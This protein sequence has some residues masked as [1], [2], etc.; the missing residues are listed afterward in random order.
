MHS[1]DWNSLFVAQWAEVRLSVDMGVRSVGPT[2]CCG[3]T[4]VGRSGTTDNT[5]TNFF[6]YF[7]HALADRKS[8]LK[9]LDGTSECCVRGDTRIGRRQLLIYLNHHQSNNCIVQEK[10]RRIMTQTTPSVRAT[11]FSCPHCGA[12]AKQ[13]WH[14]VWS[15]RR[16][17]KHPQPNIITPEQESTL[18]FSAGGPEVEAELRAWAKK[19]ASGIPHLEQSG[20]GQWIRNQVQNVNLSSCYNCKKLSVWIF[21]RLVYPTTNTSLAANPDMPEDVRRDYDEA[22]TIVKESPRGAAAL[23]RLAIQKLCRQLGQPGKN[24]NADIAALVK[25]GL[26]TRV[27]Q[28][29]DVVRVVGNNAVHPGQID[30]R[31]DKATAESLFTLINLIVDKTISEPKHVEEMYSSL[32]DG[33]RIAIEKRDSE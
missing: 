15:V 23:L 7:A 18:D 12:L 8:I 4:G 25:S 2:N 14:D 9:A 1:A 22:S 11:S 27:Q 31:D 28:A 3:G 21:D 6:L 17:E 20:E 30:L 19:M 32:P 26:D 33:A 29:L 10:T 13:F 16:G 24:I 5:H